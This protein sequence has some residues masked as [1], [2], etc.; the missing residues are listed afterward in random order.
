MQ[1]KEW[2]KTRK[3]TEHK[4]SEHTKRKRNTKVKLSKASKQ[5]KRSHIEKKNTES[6]V[7][8]PTG[9]CKRQTIYK[10]DQFGGKK[11]INQSKNTL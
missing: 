7:G 9:T 4:P 3:K 10:N 1:E 8:K 6:E 5:R 11:T 2:N